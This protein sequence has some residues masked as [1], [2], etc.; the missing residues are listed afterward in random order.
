MITRIELKNFMSHQHTVI[1]P[2]RGLTVISGP[3]NC[4]KS[5]IVTALQILCYNDESTFVTRHDEKECSIT[6]STHDGHE[7]QWQRNKNKS[8]KYII[9]GQ[10][11]DRLGRGGTPDV[12]HEILGIRRV[13]CDN[14]DFDVHFGAQKQPV[15]LLND[16]PRAAAQFFASSSD[17]NNLIAMQTKHKQKIRDQKTI[18][19]RLAAELSDAKKQLEALS[20]VNK[21]LDEL[22]QAESQYEQIVSNAED[23][24]AIY[25]QMMAIQSHT[26]QQQQLKS[27]TETLQPLA[28]PPELPST[29]TLENLVNQI[30]QNQA[31]AF[32]AGTLVKALVALTPPPA[33]TDTSELSELVVSIQQLDTDREWAERAFSSFQGI[34]EPP[35]LLPESPLRNM[36]MRFQEHQQ[37][38]ES[39]ESLLNATSEIGPIPTPV[40]FSQ[41]DELVLEMSDQFRKIEK[42]RTQ[43][44]DT[45]SQISEVES[46]IEGWVAENPSC[47]TCGGVLTAQQLLDPNGAHQHG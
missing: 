24:V 17:A 36:V 40:D 15:F 43:V 22:E 23:A 13:D 5:A 11:Y 1:E 2:A 34:V 47:P 9:D 46:L 27:L 12:L 31:S 41:I 8:T 20:P 38:V 39:L 30:Q 18:K 6:V 21:I 25:N 29:Q 42:L 33:S 3:N 4:G 45:E 19:T 16:S 35:Q 32:T 14:Q 37:S 44:A 26:R 10:Q 7:I 28:A